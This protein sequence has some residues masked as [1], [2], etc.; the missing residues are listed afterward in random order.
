[1]LAAA[2]ET[3]TALEIDANPSRL[4]LDEVYARRAAD[5]GVLLTVDT[6]A[7]SPDH[8]DF[9]EYGL[10]VARRAWLEPR[11]LLNC[12]GDEEI[13]AWLRERKG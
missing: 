11:H 2:V 3:Q 9:L 10:G 5:L 1:V 12:R 4:D 6:D 13:L 7:H 8:L